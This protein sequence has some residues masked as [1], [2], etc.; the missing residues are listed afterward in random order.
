MINITI[1]SY[2]KFNFINLI[3]L[4]N[5]KFFTN[6]II[7]DFDYNRFIL[8]NIFSFNLFYNNNIIDFTSAIKFINKKIDFRDIYIFVNRITNVIRN[9]FIVI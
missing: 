3:D 7:I 4:L 2:I 8:I 9:K 6:I 1:N 5:L